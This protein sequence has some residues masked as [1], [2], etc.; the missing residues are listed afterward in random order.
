MRVYINGV[1]V[2]EDFSSVRPFGAL[3]PTRVPGIGIGNVQDLYDFPFLGAID[4]V[5]LYNR[6]LSPAEV[7][8]LVPEPSSATLLFPSAGLLWGWSGRKRA[9]IRAV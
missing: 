6:A 1:L 5:V 3:D 9:F 4:E 7:A 2:A 8:S